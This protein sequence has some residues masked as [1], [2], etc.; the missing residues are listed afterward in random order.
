M[1]VVDASILVVALADDGAD[2]DRAR[3]RLRGEALAAPELIDLE[4]ASVLRRQSAAGRLDD[5]RARLC[6][7]DLSELALQRTRHLPLLAR[8]WDLRG[9]VTV[10]DAAYVARLVPVGGDAADSRREACQGNR[11]AMRDRGSRRGSRPSHADF[12]WAQHD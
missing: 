9:N 3:Y 7:S 4:V 8:C 2:G 5:R 1:L 12:T 6:L 10:Y 11:T